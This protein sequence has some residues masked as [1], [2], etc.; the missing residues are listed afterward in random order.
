MLFVVPAGAASG[1]GQVTVSNQAPARGVIEVWSTGWKPGA[2]VSVLLT[3]TEGVIARATADATGAVKTWVSVP[4]DAA[5]GREVLS[6]V[7]STTGGS[8]GDRH[9]CSVRAPAH[10]PAPSRPW[11]AVFFS[12]PARRC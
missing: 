11:T 2:V 1:L 3:G 6:V 5:T 7:G 4:A 9:R 12:H 10:R 8:A